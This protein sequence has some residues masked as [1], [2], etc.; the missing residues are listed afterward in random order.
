M[1]DPKEPLWHFTGKQIV[2]GVMAVVSMTIGTWKAISDKANKS[3]VDAV[4]LKVSGLADKKDVETLRNE[5]NELSAKRREDFV[6]LKNILTATE[7]T[8]A[9]IT[10]I[11]DN[12][13]WQIQQEVKR[14]Q[15]QNFKTDP[16][17]TPPVN[18]NK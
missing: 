18:V 7:Q 4:V 10:K 6:M 2:V 3:E 9:K 15:W 5:L 8:N 11:E 16:P 17:S 14:L 13:V 12:Q 1:P